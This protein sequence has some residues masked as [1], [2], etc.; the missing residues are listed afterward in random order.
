MHD[1]TSHVFFARTV[2]LYLPVTK[3][4]CG[5]T[6]S[7]V[8]CRGTLIMQTGSHG[9]TRFVGGIRDPDFKTYKIIMVSP[10]LFS[11][12]VWVEPPGV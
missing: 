5:F 8:V 2:I 1:V 11:N 9:D 3:V 12:P 4:F 7:V 10:G 6:E